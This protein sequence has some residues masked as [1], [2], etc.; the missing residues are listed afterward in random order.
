M[1]KINEKYNSEFTNQLVKNQDIFREIY[2]ACNSTFTKSCA[3][4]FFDGQTYAYCDAM[5]KK[6]ELL[7]NKVKDSKNV[8]EIGSYM[9]HSTLIML[10]S[11]PNLKITC[12]DINDTFSIPAIN[13]INKYFNNA[14]TFIH[15]DSITALT[16]MTDKFDF[17]HVDGSSDIEYV[18]DEF[19]LLEPLN[20]NETTNNRMK[21]I[22]ND[23]ES[24]VDLQQMIVQQNIVVDYIVP[25]CVISNVYFEVVMI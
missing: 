11:N 1:E 13:V 8:L 25:D 17:F 9:G 12:I 2:E 5:Y 20:D 19:R 24:R 14:I 22:F 3:S 4:Y 21:I 23:H 6:Q 16:T 10:L 7:Y 15:S 18:Q